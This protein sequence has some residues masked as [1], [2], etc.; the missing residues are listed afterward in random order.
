MKAR[1]QSI[2]SVVIGAV[3]LCTGSLLAEDINELQRNFNQPPDDSRIMMRWWWFGPAVTKPELEREMKLMK[4]GGI[5][6]IEVQPTYPLSLDDEKAGIKNF[7]FMSPEFLDALNF[8]AEK[9]KELGL[10]MDLTLGSGWPYGGPQFPPS[11]AAGRLRTVNVSITAGKS[12]V[13]L[14]KVRDGEKV[15][16]AFIGPMQNVKAG[17]NPFKE[18]EIR[19]NA[20]QLPADLGGQTQVTFFIASQTKMKVKRA[21]YGAEGFVIDHYNPAVIEKFIKEIAEPALKACWA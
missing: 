7:K 4:E 17:E 21:A 18:V 2:I 20:A 14:P 3:L 1:S 11:E 8:T 15:F 16:A 19:D 12:S 9:A 10:R 13:P 5:G 6:G